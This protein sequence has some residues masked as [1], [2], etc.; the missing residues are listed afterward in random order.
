MHLL[1]AARLV[2]LFMRLFARNGV[3]TDVGWCV[4]VFGWDEVQR[5]NRTSSMYQ[6]L[7]ILIAS[8]PVARAIYDG[9]VR[10]RLAV[11]YEKVVFAYFIG[12]SKGSTMS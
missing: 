12:G 9:F 8:D 1:P 2:H 5:V 6:M 11:D 4:C 7:Y 3:N 10:E